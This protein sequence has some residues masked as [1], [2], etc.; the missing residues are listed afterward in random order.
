[1]TVIYKLVDNTNDNC[2]IGS[3][4]NLCSRKKYHRNM[5]DCSCKHIIENN[6]YHY[7][8]LEE[9]DESI[10]FQRE[11]YYIEITNN[12]VN[13]N[14]AFGNDKEKYKEYQKK[15]HKEQNEYQYS[16]GGDKRASNNLLLIDVNLF[17]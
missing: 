11:Q 14:R 12:C 8:V 13:I 5:K 2:Y 15:Y 7:I 4:V 17:L 16:W 6:N 10:R 3:T 9:C 1:M